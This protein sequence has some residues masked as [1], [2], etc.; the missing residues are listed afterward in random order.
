M[1]STPIILPTRT[2]GGGIPRPPALEIPPLTAT[3]FDEIPTSLPENR[4]DIMNETPKERLC[5]DLYM[6]LSDLRSD[7]I[8][9]MD[10]KRYVF[11]DS[12]NREESLARIRAEEER[13]QKLIAAVRLV[14]DSLM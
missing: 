4:R 12:P 11:D 5:T 2:N 6:Y 7:L 9:T 8:V 14:I 13:L 1:A 10:S 3:T